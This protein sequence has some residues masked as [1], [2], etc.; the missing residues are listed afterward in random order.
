MPYINAMVGV[1]FIVAPQKIYNSITL[2]LSRKE[3]QQLSKIYSSYANDAILKNPIKSD[4][5]ETHTTQKS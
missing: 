1:A 3:E 4:N 2:F 5:I